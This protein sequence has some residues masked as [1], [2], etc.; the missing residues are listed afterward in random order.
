MEALKANFLQRIVNVFNFFF[1]LQK[2]SL[3]N[4][5]SELCYALYRRFVAC[6]QQASSHKIFLKC[7]AAGPILD[8]SNFCTKTCL[9]EVTLLLIN[10]N[11]TLSYT[12]KMG[13]TRRLK[14]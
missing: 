13:S 5:F 1:F 3:T 14:I 8:F 12:R 7:I 6:Q 10:S 2:N 9:F 4:L 11:D